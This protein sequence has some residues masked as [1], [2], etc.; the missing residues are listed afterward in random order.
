M[1]RGVLLLL[2]S[3]MKH[4]NRLLCPAFS[5]DVVRRG[6][7]FPPPPPPPAPDTTRSLHKQQNNNRQTQ[8]VGHVLRSAQRAPRQ[9]VCSQWRTSARTWSTP[10]IPVLTLG[11]TPKQHNNNNARLN[12]N[13]PSG[14]PPSALCPPAIQTSNLPLSTNLWCSNSY[15]Y[16]QSPL[17]TWCRH[18]V[19]QGKL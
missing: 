18:K 16:Y 19:F 12:N 5:L 15:N 14:A 2:V 11:A 3:F 10:S 4:Q 9:R 13:R 1:Q 7:V 6:C 17:I 8:Q